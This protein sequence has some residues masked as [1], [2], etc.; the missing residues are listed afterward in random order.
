MSCTSPHTAYRSLTRTNPDTKNAIIT[1]KRPL[2]E[3]VEEITIN[4]GNCISCRIARSREWA[5]RCTHE[6]QNWE[7]N[8]FITL[9]INDANLPNKKKQCETCTI[10][11]R[12]DKRTC[13]NGSLCKQDFQLFMKRL[14][15]RYQGYEPIPGT[16]RYPIRYFHC[17][18][19]GTLLSRPHHHACLFNFNF[20]DRYRWR[21]SN[22]SSLA[23]NG[24]N[25]EIKLYRSE[26]LEELWPYGF[27]TIGEVTWQSAAYVARYVTKKINGD[28]AAVHYL[29]GDPDQETGECQY[30]EPEFVSMSRMPG[31]GKYWYDKYGPKQYEKDY[32]THEGNKFP[33]PGFYDKMFAESNPARMKQILKERRQRANERSPDGIKDRIQQRQAKAVELEERFTKLMRSIEENDFANV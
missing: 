6:A 18:E 26:S 10:Y 16:K 27:C 11:K 28:M 17:G 8:C 12:N 24:A 30:I 23:R 22:I 14:R 9:T 15:K 32:I 21:S 1:F 3:P 7:Q 25:P 2:R 33:I 29:V 20:P 31:L 5:L 19:Y 4:C 13:L